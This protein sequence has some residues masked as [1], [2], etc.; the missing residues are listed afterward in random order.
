MPQ[1]RWWMWVVPALKL[2][3]G[4]IPAR[5]DRVMALTIAKVTRKPSDA[6]NSRSRIS[7]LKWK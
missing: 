7:L 2:W 6:R 3:N 1:T 5:I 4:P